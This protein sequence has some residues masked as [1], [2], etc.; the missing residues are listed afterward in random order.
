AVVVAAVP[1]GLFPAMTV[2]LAIGM[3]RLACHKGL[4]RK[5]LA[6]ETLGS[7]SVICADKTGTLTQ[8]EMRVSEVITET[9][10]ISHDSTRFPPA[11]RHGSQTIQPDGEA[12]HIVALKIGLLCNN[13]I[14]E[15]PEKKLKDWVVVG[16]PTE[17]ALLLA[18]RAAGLKKEDLE[19]K[20]PRIAEIPFDSVYKFMATLHKSGKGG[21]VYAK[22]APEKILTLS[23]LVDIEGRRTTLTA[24]KRKEIQKQYEHLTSLGLRVLAVAYK[25]E[26]AIKSPEKFN[27]NNLDDLVFVGL[28]ALKDP[29]RPEAKK[30]IALCQKAG[31]RPIVVTGDHKLMLNKLP[32]T[33]KLEDTFS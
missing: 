29:L 8:G 24:T 12:S 7:V 23:S 5:M 31:I 6:A 18:A 15:N 33:Q 25:L 28:V 32:N 13:A 20:E 19:K 4:V 2:I 11:G 21:I 14:V 27:K 16:D 22:G 30:T 10:K 3:Q 26:D 17:K 9:A 1:E